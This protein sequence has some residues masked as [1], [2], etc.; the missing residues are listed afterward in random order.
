[1]EIQFFDAEGICSE[2]ISQ[3]DV[4]YLGGGGKDYNGQVS[5]A[6]L[7]A[8]P[9][10]DLKAVLAGE[11]EV[12]EDEHG[13]REFVTVGELSFAAE[14]G[15]GV[16]A[17]ANVLNGILEGG[18]LKGALHEEDVILPVFNNQYEV[19]IVHNKSLRRPM[20]V[21]NGAARYGVNCV[22]TG[23]ELGGKNRL[24]FM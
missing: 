5:K 7:L 2:A 11:F 16:F 23:R 17:G 9:G 18:S 1:V 6:V 12:Q 8:N 21:A 15:D 19:A 10:E 24:N 4:T 20:F 14:V 3:I 13:K 22:Y